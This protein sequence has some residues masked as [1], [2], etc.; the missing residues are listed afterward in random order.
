MADAQVGR[1]TDYK[2][3]YC[4]QAE[5]LCLLGHTD[6]ELAEFFEVVVATIYNWKNEHPEFLEATK[7]GKEIA[8]ANV[9]QSMYKN[10]CGHTVA[11]SYHPPNPTSGIFWLKNRQPKKWRDRQEVTGADGAPIVPDTVSDIETARRVA[12]LLQRGTVAIEK[13]EKDG[14][15]T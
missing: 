4:E 5:K 7:R 8:D 12:F 11:G 3:E 14:I 13:G 1:P 9:A 10:A 2:P 15:P 6:A